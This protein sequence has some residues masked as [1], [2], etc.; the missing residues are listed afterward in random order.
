MPAGASIDPGLAAAAHRRRREPAH[1]ARAGRPARPR[2]RTATAAEIAGRLHLSE[3]TVRN[4][5]SAAIR[6]LGARNRAEAIRIADEKG[7]L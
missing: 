6:K 4:Y 3:G 1:R 7:W 5:L 2:R